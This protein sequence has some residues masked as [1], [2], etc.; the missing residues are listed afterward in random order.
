MIHLDRGRRETGGTP[1]GCGVNGP[2]EAGVCARLALHTEVNLRGRMFRWEMGCTVKLYCSRVTTVPQFPTYNVEL[3][4]ACIPQVYCE[5][6]NTF[7]SDT[8]C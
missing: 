7:Y 2:L 4:V 3:R 5:G 1:S 6:E 8:A